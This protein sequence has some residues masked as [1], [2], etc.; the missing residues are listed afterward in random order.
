MLR[1]AIFL[2]GSLGFLSS[3]RADVVHVGDLVLWPLAVVARLFK[4]APRIVITAY[5][6][7]VIYGRRRGWLPKLYALYLGLGVRLV[8]RRVRIIAIS[9]E[10]ARLCRAAGFPDVSVVTLG[11]DPPQPLP[12]AG[13]EPSDY[14][15]FVGRLVRRKGA[16]WFANDVMPHLPASLNMVVVGKAWDPEELA[17]LRKNPRVDYREVVSGEQ[18]SS[19]RR[20][21]LAVVMPNI[22]S[23]GND[24]EGF[25][26]TAVEAGAEGGVLLASGIEGIVDAVVD[27]TTGFLLPAGDAMAWVSKVVEVRA[28]TPRQRAEFILACQDEIATRYSWSTVAQKTVGV[29]DVPTEEPR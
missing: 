15:L 1:L 25:G 22:P 26:L 9:Q 24:V 13:D 6:L 3:R 8:A 29:Y 21:A 17:S 7:D 14:V 23:A 16:A 19:L 5:G 18:L 20:A 27:G 4:T 12:V 28:W 11:V 10:T 2:I